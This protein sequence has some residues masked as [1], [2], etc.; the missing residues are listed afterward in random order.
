MRLNSNSKTEGI[1]GFSKGTV[2]ISSFTQE[3][4]ASTYHH[5]DADFGWAFDSRTRFSDS[6]LHLH[7]VLN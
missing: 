5:C 3:A 4:L 2:D 7:V 6:A 1:N